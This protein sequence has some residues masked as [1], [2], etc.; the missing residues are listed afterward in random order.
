MSL[1]V[2]CHPQPSISE[3]YCKIN[4]WQSLSAVATD[5]SSSCKYNHRLRESS[6][7]CPPCIRAIVEH[8]SKLKIGSLI[9]ITC[10]GAVIGRESSNTVSVPDIG[11]SK[12]S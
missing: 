12:V 10:T 6:P 11:V 9:L 8:S 2:A 7:P 1:M 3:I 5:N 4:I